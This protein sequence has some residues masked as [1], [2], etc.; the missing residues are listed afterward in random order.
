M[1]SINDDIII[2]VI[3]IIARRRKNYVPSSERCFNEN[4][5]KKMYAHLEERVTHSGVPLY[6]DGQCEVNGTIKADVS[7]GEEDW[8]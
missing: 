7:Q 1:Q 6:G 8:N 3:V 5:R 4:E 2:V